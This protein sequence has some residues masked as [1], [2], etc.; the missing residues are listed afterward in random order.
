ML[1]ASI[2]FL[3]TILARYCNATSVHFPEYSYLNHPLYELKLADPGSLRPVV[4][5]KYYFYRQNEERVYHSM[6]APRAASYLTYPC[7]TPFATDLDTLFLPHVGLDDSNK[8]KFLHIELNHAARVFVLMTGSGLYGDAL[9]GKPNVT[10]IPSQDWGTPFGV[11]TMD[12]KHERSFG[13]PGRL[14][15]LWRTPYWGFVSEVPVSDQ[16]TVSLPH[17][18]TISIN[19]KEISAYTI[20]FASPDSS[21][22]SAFPAPDLPAPF[23]AFV[24]DWHNTRPD[25]DPLTDRP[26]PNHSCPKWLHDL[27]VTPSRTG[28][29]VDELGEPAYFRTWHPMVDPVYWCYF[30]HEHGAFPGNYRPMFGYTA[31][32]T[33]SE[34]SPT[35][36]QLESH[37]GFKVFSFP[38]PNTDRVVI[39]TVHMHLSR[40]RRFT[41]RRHTAIFA[42]ARVA[43]NTSWEMEMELHM[44]M[45]FGP[46][47]VSFENRSTLPVNDEQ[48]MIYNELQRRKRMASRRINVLD[49][50]NFPDSVDT[51]YALNSDLSSGERTISR[52]VYEQWK[53]PL[54]SCSGSNGL[55]N[56]GFTFDIKDPATGTRSADHLDDDNLQ[57]LRGKSINKAL[58]IGNDGVKISLEH[59]RFDIFKSDAVI[60][61]QEQ[62]GVFYTDPRFEYVLAGS[63]LFSVRQFI[64]PNFEPLEIP[65]GHYSPVGPWYTWMELEPNRGAMRH[66]QEIEY[67][68][69]ATIN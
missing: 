23:T 62:N 6:F 8:E 56:R 4:L 55:I 58:S 46:T 14:N 3:L 51:K 9:I 5:K 7:H 33:R 63:D 60:R 69:D 38:V 41:S 47:E 35:G 42:V 65:A 31:W 11:K 36:R 30:D 22:A 40:A 54:N 37:E 45:D 25:V 27:Y 57:R 13:Q 18:R 20:L 29:D 24:G 1:R 66:F 26:V 53:G 32:K 49:L 68:V 19:G 52:G 17:P 2:W 48:W 50:S 43:N 39:S 67:A 16:L 64:S 28:R 61:L 44:K 59:C 15:Q 10:G 12:T 34:N 21:S